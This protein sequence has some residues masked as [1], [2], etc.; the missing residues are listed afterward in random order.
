MFRP[1]LSYPWFLIHSNSVLGGSCFILLTTLFRK[2]VVS[3]NLLSD[4]QWFCMDAGMEG[5]WL[6]FKLMLLVAIGIAL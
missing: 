5:G 4:I 3:N 2:S 6:V 1:I